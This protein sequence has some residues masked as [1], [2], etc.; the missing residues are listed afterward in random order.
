MLDPPTTENVNTGGG[1]NLEPGVGGQGAAGGQGEAEEG[2]VGPTPVPMERVE[3]DEIHELDQTQAQ[4]D[5]N[6]DFKVTTVEG[7]LVFECT[8]VERSMIQ[9]RK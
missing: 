3:L 2:Y 4:V 8:H 5:D 1:E 9:K 6:E 7:E